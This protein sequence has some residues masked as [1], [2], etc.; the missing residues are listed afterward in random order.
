VIPVSATDGHRNNIAN[1]HRSSMSPPKSVSRCTLVIFEPS[2]DLQQL[3]ADRAAVKLYHLPR[4]PLDS[5]F[6]A[7]T[8]LVAPMM[9]RT[10]RYETQ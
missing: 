3:S 4:S 1:A 6:F 9:Q 10:S 8:I 2:A 5:S 7:R